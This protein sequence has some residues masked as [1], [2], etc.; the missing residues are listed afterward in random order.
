MCVS[1]GARM[2]PI[3]RMHA[4]DCVHAHIEYQDCIVIGKEAGPL[5]ASCKTC[6]HFGCNGM[7]HPMY[8]HLNTGFLLSF[9]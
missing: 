5:S 8:H 6:L 3:V 1:M 7:P 2:C 9:T 4:Y